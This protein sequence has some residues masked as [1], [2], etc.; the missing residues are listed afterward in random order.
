MHIG[1]WHS[2]HTLGLDRPSGHDANTMQKS[3][4]RHH[5][6]R[7]LLC[8]GNCRGNQYSIKPYNFIENS[9]EY[10]NAEW[11]IKGTISPYRS[12]IDSY[13]ANMDF[14]S[15]Q[16]ENEQ[17]SWFAEK[18]NRIQLKNMIDYIRSLP[19]CIDSQAQLS[20]DI[21]ELTTTFSDRIEVIKFPSNFPT[22][23]ISIKIKY[24]NS[25][26]TVLK[27]MSDNNNIET[28][29]G[30]LYE[31]FKKQYNTLTHDNT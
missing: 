17:Q 22:D 6:N 28:F 1:E 3:I 4:N 20:G 19:Y 5:L 2:H 9:S 30:N 15:R 25:T 11:E 18:S 31:A 27:S 8:I 16:Y 10:S 21:V 29:S 12:Q 23:A 13:L 7:F 14:T 26:E 24:H